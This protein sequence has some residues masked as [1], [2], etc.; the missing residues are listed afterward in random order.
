MTGPKILL[1]MN[2]P[3]LDIPG[4]ISKTLKMKILK[5]LLQRRKNGWPV[6]E[7]R[8]RLNPCLLS[9]KRLLDSGGKPSTLTRKGD[10]LPVFTLH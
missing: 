5:T 6:K 4:E 9:S 3:P 8:I 2:E 10:F 7:V 1:T